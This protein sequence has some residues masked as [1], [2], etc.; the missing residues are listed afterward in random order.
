MH[1]PGCGAEAPVTQKFCRSCGFCLEKVPNLVAEQLSESKE[2]LTS[3]AAEKLQERQQNMRNVIFAINTTLD[4]CVDHTKQIADEE[5][6]EYFTDLLRSVDLLVFGRKTYQLMVPFWPEVAKTQSMTR[7]SN[8]FARTFVSLNK[9]VFSRSLES[10]EDEN[11]RIVR[12]N[13]R[14]EI[15]KLKQEQGKSIL[16]GGVSI[17]SQL[18][19]LGLVDEYR[20]VVNPLVAGEGRRLLEGVNLPESLQVRLVESKIFKSGSVALHYLKQ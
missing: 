10:A 18:I 7:A 20:F 15:L 11:T 8:E 4:G 19:E 17:P 13:P 2:L 14:D 6:H 9:I 12:T 1:C 16:L 3:A 5:T